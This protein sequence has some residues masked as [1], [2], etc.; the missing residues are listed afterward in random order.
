V[1]YDLSS[2]TGLVVNA[3]PTRR[4]AIERAFGWGSIAMFSA[5]DERYHN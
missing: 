2:L 3:K 5:A 4:L 1:G